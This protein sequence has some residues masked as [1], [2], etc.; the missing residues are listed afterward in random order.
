[1]LP[2]WVFSA[3]LKQKINTNNLAK[4]QA[5]SNIKMWYLVKQA[6]YKVSCP[7]PLNII[8]PGLLGSSFFCFWCENNYLFRRLW[9]TLR[10]CYNRLSYCRWKYLIT[11]KTWMGEEGKGSFVCLNHINVPVRHMLAI[12]RGRQKPANRAPCLLLQQIAG[13]ILHALSHR[14]D[15][16]W[17]AFVEP[18]L[19]GTSW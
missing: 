10:F 19:V 13:D 6:W 16:T 14:H 3:F 1:M 4:F 17:T 8:H 15:Y 2:F 7:V 18:A 11:Q 12:Y 9:D 5:W